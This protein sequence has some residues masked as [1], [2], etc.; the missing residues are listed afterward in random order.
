MSSQA[1]QIKL[2]ER[3]MLNGH[4]KL[5]GILLLSV[6]FN[7]TFALFTE[8]ESTLSTLGNLQRKAIL[9]G[10]SHAGRMTGYSFLSS[11]LLVFPIIGWGILLICE[12]DGGGCI[13]A[14]HKENLERKKIREERFKIRKAKR[15]LRELVDVA[16]RIV[17]GKSPKFS[18]ELRHFLANFLYL[19]YTQEELIFEITDY[20]AKGMDGLFN[21]NFYQG[22][23]Y[24]KM[25][26]HIYK[27][28]KDKR[29]DKVVKTIEILERNKNKNKHILVATEHKTEHIIV[30]DK[31][32]N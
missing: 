31:E 5:I 25:V 23:Y 30:P 1:K 27:Y 16:S 4:K 26:T 11:G 14:A 22:D 21:H 28:L 13:S 12:T 3:I 20:N 18:N 32:G 17:D 10:R 8:N 29:P 6:T 24:G 9:E 19:P 7:Q 15:I 2:K